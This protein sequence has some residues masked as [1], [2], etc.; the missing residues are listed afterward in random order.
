MVVRRLDEDSGLISEAWATIASNTVIII[1]QIVYIC[2]IDRS[3][4]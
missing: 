4:K 3:E 1:M 2:W